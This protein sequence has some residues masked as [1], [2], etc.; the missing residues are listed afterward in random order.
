MMS[1]L[2][3]KTLDGDVTVDAEH[4]FELT[5]VKFR[6]RFNHAIFRTLL[7]GQAL[8]LTPNCPE[9]FHYRQRAR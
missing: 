4:V 8:P 2:S 1:V 6:D 7:D 9:L 5:P 3:L